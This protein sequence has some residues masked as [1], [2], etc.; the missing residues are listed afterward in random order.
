MKDRFYAAAV[1]VVISIFIALAVLIL[2]FWFWFP[3]PLITLGAVEGVQLI[4]VVDLVVG[5]VCT[6]MV[7]KKGKPGMLFDLCVIGLLQISALSYGMWMVSTQRPAYMVV[8]HTGIEIVSRYDEKLHLNEEQRKE[9]SH[10]LAQTLRYEGR[11][12]IIQIQELGDTPRARAMDRIRYEFEAGA[13]F[14]FNMEKYSPLNDLLSTPA[15]SN[16]AFEQQDGCV[17]A[18]FSS[19]HGKTDACIAERNG[20]IVKI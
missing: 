3:A 12:P 7:F 14:V 16:G 1:H 4:L 2:L 10:I 20:K 13:A 8:S 5:P 18:Q 17:L 11:I 15:I 19:P 9:L 6:L